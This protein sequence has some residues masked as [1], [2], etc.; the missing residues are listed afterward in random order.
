MCMVTALNYDWYSAHSFLL[1]L[2]P[3]IFI[4]VKKNVVSSTWHPVISYC[5][6]HDILFW[7]PVFSV[8]VI[9]KASG[10]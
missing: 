10:S 8:L 3:C 1:V 7:L 5:T 6:Q 9:H 2:F 4:C